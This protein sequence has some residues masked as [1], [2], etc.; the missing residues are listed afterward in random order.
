MRRHALSQ[1]F[2]ENS[3]ALFARNDFHPFTREELGT[4]S[5]D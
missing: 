3:E 5:T 2:A 1:Y 4:A